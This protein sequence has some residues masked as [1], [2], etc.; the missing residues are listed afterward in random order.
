LNRTPVIG[1]GSRSR[2]SRSSSG[3]T[4]SGST[5]SDSAR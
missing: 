3:R 4:P 5:T 2:C 1:F